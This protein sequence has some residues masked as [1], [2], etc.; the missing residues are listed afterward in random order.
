[1]DNELQKVWENKLKKALAVD[2]E[3]ALQETAQ[4]L[5]ETLSQVPRQW[6]VYDLVCNW[7]ISERIVGASLGITQQG[8][9]RVLAKL[10]HKFPGLR[11]TPRKHKSS[12]PLPD[13]YH[14]PGKTHLAGCKRAYK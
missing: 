14:Q 2:R 8:V 5:I 6:V 3:T 11:P 1:M 10:L 9:S 12:E 4:H 7:G 13:G